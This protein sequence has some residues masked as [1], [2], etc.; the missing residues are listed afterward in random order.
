MSKYLWTAGVLVAAMAGAL[1][2][3]ALPAEATPSVVERAVQ[4]KPT[5]VSDRE[6]V[7]LFVGQGRLV[8]DHPGLAQYV[9]VGQQEL[10]PAQVVAVVDAYREAYPRFHEDV[11]V[12][13]QSGDPYRVLDALHA[14]E[15]ATSRIADTEPIAA[16]GDG[17][18]LVVLAAGVLVWLG[19]SVYTYFW[20]T[21]SSADD[22]GA[23]FAA[24]LAHSLR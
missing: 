24:E 11:T 5:P 22:A 14:F 2:V 3:P 19:V 15:E 10:T 18:C 4:S 17:R 6:V 13:L 21:K 12:P 16:A 7:E 8:A 23:A 1:V 9:P 20:G